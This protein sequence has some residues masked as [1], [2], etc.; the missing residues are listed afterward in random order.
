MGGVEGC[1]S[2]HLAEEGLVSLH[3]GMVG[4]ILGEQAGREGLHG[5]MTEQRGPSGDE[6]CC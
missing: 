3:V 4:A 1:F 2:E 6:C 5:G